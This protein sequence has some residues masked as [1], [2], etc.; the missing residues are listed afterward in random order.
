MADIHQSLTGDRPKILIEWEDIRYS[1]TIKN[2]ETKVKE[3]K[4]I[5]HGVN[6]F[7]NPGQFLAIMGASGAGKTTL[8]NILSDRIAGGSS[9]ISGTIKTNG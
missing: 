8:L 7:A 2:K 1:V 3:E 4:E 5:L 9:K 6:G